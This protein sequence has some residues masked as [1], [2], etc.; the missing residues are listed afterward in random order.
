MSDPVELRRIGVLSPFDE[1]RADI[2]RWEKEYPHAEHIV[3]VVSNPDG[4]EFTT[5]G[6]PLKPSSL[7]GLFFLAAHTVCE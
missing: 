2:T 1:A 7:A 4:I 3:M 5:A 6:G